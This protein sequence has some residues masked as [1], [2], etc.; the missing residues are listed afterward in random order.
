MKKGIIYYLKKHHRMFITSKP[1]NTQ[2]IIDFIDSADVVHGHYLDDPK[3]TFIC[4]K[5]EFSRIFSSKPS[6]NALRNT[7]L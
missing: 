5:H 7:K 6:L 4:C 1:E 3:T 2:A